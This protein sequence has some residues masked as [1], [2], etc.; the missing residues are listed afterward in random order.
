[1]TTTQDGR[2]LISS[3][4]DKNEVLETIYCFVF[5]ERKPSYIVDVV[6]SDTLIGMLQGCSSVSNCIKKCMSTELKED[7]KRI[8]SG[9]RHLYGGD[10]WHGYY[11]R[12]LDRGYSLNTA[13]KFMIDRLE[14]GWEDEGN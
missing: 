13:A 3:D 4:K 11:Y 8:K 2:I 1:M 12:E 7:Y 9:V 5:W 14:V 6:V 10:K